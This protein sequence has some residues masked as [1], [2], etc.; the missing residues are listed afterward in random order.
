LHDHLSRI[1]QADRLIHGQSE[2]A[3]SRSSGLNFLPR[4]NTAAF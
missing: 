3:F 2:Q 1:L 4:T